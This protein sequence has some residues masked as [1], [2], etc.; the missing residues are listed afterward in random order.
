MTLKNSEIFIGLVS[1][2]KVISLLNDI[3]TEVFNKTSSDNLTKIE[4]L[5]K[6]FRS[7]KNTFMEFWKRLGDILL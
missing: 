6:E 7:N 3:F 2:A 4:S 5:E 1:K